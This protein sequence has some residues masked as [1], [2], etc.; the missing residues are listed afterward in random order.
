MAA[1]T[2]QALF[3]EARCFCPL[4]SEAYQT[5]KLVLLSQILTGLGIT[6][7]LPELMEYGKCYGCLGL[8]PAEQAELALLDLIL[9]NGGGGGGGINTN[10]GGVVDPEGVV[11][12]VQWGRY[13]ASGTATDWVK[14]S[15][16]AGTT[17][18]QQV[19]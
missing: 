3:A 5:M 15:P 19:S 16:G 1:T 7:T 9:A 12:G 13:F 18:W 8:T 4:T 11:S 10:D 6:M 14:T 17:G 2:P